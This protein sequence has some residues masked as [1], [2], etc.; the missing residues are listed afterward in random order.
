MLVWFSFHPQWLV[1]AICAASVALVL[2]GFVTAT[3]APMS[4]IMHVENCTVESVRADFARG[5][6]RV[7]FEFALNEDNAKRATALAAQVGDDM[8]VTL[9]VVGAQASLF[10]PVAEAV[11]NL[12]PQAGSGIDSVEISSGDRSVTLTPESREWLDGAQARA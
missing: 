1:P 10:D 2:P 4:N 12:A 9:R 6:I 11:R 5:R 3:E 8:R 7:T